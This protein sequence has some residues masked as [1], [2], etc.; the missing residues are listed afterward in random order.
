MFKTTIKHIDGNT[1]LPLGPE[2]LAHLGVAI[3]DEIYLTPEPEGGLRLSR[4]DPEF[5]EQMKI[6]RQVMKENEAA[7]KALK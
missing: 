6:A 7:L 4:H 2:V 3:G 5:E 1:V